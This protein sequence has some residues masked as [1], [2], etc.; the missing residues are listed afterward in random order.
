MQHT[1]KRRH[2]NR[3][4]TSTNEITQLQKE[5]ADSPDANRL[6]VLKDEIDEKINTFEKKILKSS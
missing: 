4:K 3:K 2:I 5:L 6:N 1:R